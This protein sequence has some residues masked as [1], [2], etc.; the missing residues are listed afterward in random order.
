MAVS[1]LHLLHA[2]YPA[3]PYRTTTT[4]AIQRAC[5]D[6]TDSQV[7]HSTYTCTRA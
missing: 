5:G 4:I 2:Y 3:L 7:P 6:C 1:L